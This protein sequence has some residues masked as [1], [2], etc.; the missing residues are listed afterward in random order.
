MRLHLYAASLFVLAG[1]A[2][3]M[4][5]RQEPAASPLAASAEEKFVDSCEVR[6]QEVRSSGEFGPRASLCAVMQR[7]DDKRPKTRL[8]GSKRGKGT[9]AYLGLLMDF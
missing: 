6:Y 2:C 7:D 8:C 9:A 4:Q 3:A 1:P 5:W